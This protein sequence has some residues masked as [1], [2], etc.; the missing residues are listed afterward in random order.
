MPQSWFSVRTFIGCG[1]GPM[2]QP[3]DFGSVFRVASWELQSA[4]MHFRGWP[5][6]WPWMADLGPSFEFMYP[7]FLWVAADQVFNQI[8]KARHMFGGD[9]AVPAGAAHQGRHGNRLWIAAFDGSSGH[10]PTSPGW[11]IVA[12][13]TPFDYVGLMN[14]ALACQDPVLVVE[15]VDLYASSGIYRHFEGGRGLCAEVARL[16]ADG[17]VI[18][19]VRGGWNSDPGRSGPGAFSATPATA[20]CSA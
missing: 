20:R 18:G 8:G 5:A 9:I 6:G 1:A 2:A 11:R 16:V 19:S 7:D 14:T 13:T 17:R 12:P 10:L 4:R 15:H 3:A